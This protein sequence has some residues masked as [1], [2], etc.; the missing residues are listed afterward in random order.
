MFFGAIGCTCKTGY[1]VVEDFVKY[2]S[3]FLLLIAISP[4]TPIMTR[5][6]YSQ[7]FYEDIHLTNCIEIIHATTQ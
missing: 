6:F 1:Y 2:P 7:Q 4:L 3:F 5:N